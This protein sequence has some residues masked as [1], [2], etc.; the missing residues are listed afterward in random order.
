VKKLWYPWPIPSP[1]PSPGTFQGECATGWYPE[2]A[3]LAGGC[4]DGPGADGFTTSDLA[5]KTFRSFARKKLLL[6]VPINGFE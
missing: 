6:V 4:R 5:P 1:S 2:G 3:L